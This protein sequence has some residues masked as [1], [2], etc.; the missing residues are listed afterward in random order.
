MFDALKERFWVIAE[1]RGFNRMFSGFR[2]REGWFILC[3][4]GVC[5][6]PLAMQTPDD[7]YI[8]VEAFRAEMEHLIG[9]GF[10]FVTLTEG[11]R[12]MRE[13]GSLDNLVTMTFDD[14]MQ[15][16]IDLAYPVMASL[17]VKGCMYVVANI[18]GTSR[19]LWTDMVIAVCWH[20]QGRLVLNFPQRQISFPRDG[21]G[22]PGKISLDVIRAFRTLR[23]DVR[24][25]YFEQIERMFED[26]PA[27]F[28]PREYMSVTWAQL[29]ALDPGI[30]EV[31]NHTLSHPK[32]VN[33]DRATMQ[34]EIAEARRRIEDEVGR[35]VDHFCYP[36]GAYN[37]DVV[38]CVRSAGHSS[39]TT[40]V[41]GS[42]TRGTPPFKLRRIV[43]PPTLVRFKSRLSGFERFVRAATNPRKVLWILVLLLGYQ[44]DLIATVAG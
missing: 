29:R 10:R 37:D 28:V 35:R 32:L 5:D 40:G 36:G 3:G 24:R 9:L 19:L 6:G 8:Q 23:D 12:L 26:I 31:G 38:E 4:H 42:N 41:Y 14:G 43:L 44:A 34:T 20:R 16:V 15:S 27:G 39:A 22:N 18:V 11:I 17:G 2:P 33:V 30:L 1:T 21:E 7:R 25:Q 13:G